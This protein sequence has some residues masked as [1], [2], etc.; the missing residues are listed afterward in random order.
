MIHAAAHDWHDSSRADQFGHVVI[1]ADLA[2]EDDL[3]PDRGRIGRRS[4]VL[5]VLMN[6]NRP[7]EVFGSASAV[8]AVFWMI[9]ALVGVGGI[10][11]RLQSLF[12]DHALDGDGLAHIRRYMGGAI[13]GIQARGH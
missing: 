2:R 8:A 1:F 3:V 11:D 6:T 12:V 4:D 10:T 9:E 13:I 5:V 7:S